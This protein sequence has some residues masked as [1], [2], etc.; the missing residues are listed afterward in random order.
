MITQQK[1]CFY[2]EL[3]CY[4]KVMTIYLSCCRQVAKETVFMKH[5]VPVFVFNKR[6]FTKTVPTAYSWIDRY[7]CDY[8]IVYAEKKNV[9]IELIIIIE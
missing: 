9:F 8:I 6:C 3:F 4:S 2:E 1:Y 5:L 7:S